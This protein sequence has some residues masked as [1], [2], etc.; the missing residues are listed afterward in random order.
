METIKVHTDSNEYMID[1]KNGI[2]YEIGDLISARFSLKRIFIITD[3]N[4]A[5]IYINDLK[6]S[7]QRNAICVEIIILKPGEQSKSFECYH[8]ICESLL[9]KGITRSDTILAFGGGVVGDIAGFAASTIL[10]GIRL[11]HA[12][13]SLLSQVDSSVG[14]KTAINS[15]HG[16]NLIGSF[17]QPEA[18]YIDPLLLDTL[19]KRYFSDGMAEIIKYACIKDAKLF[20]LL[21]AHDAGSIKPLMSDII[22]CCCSI[23]AEVVAKDERDTAE[24]MLLNFGHTLGHVIESYFDYSKYTHGEAV[25]LGMLKITT[26]SEEMGLTE[27]GVFEKLEK[28]LQIYDLPVEY[29]LMENEKAQQILL[30]DK[31]TESDNINLIILRKIG[32]AYIHKTDIA[33]CIEFLL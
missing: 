5:A 10:R 17:Y 22:A 31:K 21:E 18:V 14:G 7:F 13:S 32:E 19:S 27:K 1:I 16:K 6:V 3:E 20:E 15:T 2:F 26:R 9:E 4:V 29:P 11:I 12:P 28:L 30:K 24:R 25:A 8:M 33:A 23:K